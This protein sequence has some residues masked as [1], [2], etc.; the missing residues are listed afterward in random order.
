MPAWLD[1]SN[2]HHYWAY[3]AELKRRGL[4]VPREWS[5][6]SALMSAEP[7]GNP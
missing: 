5:E 3:V 7:M 6:Y 2:P 1:L 4:Y